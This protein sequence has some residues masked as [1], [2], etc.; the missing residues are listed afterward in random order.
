MSTEMSRDEFIHIWK[1]CD[2]KLDKSLT[3]NLY[4]VKDMQMRKVRTNLNS[5]IATRIL[6]IVFGLAWLLLLCVA[7]YFV[8]TQIVMAVSIGVFIICTGVAIIDY[9]RDIMTLQHISY[10]ESILETQE[11]LAVLQRSMIRSIRVLWL[12]L[13]FW[14]TFFISNAFIRDGGIRF[15]IIQT[16]I[17]LFFVGLTV[18]LFRNL[19]PENMNKKK[20]V[21]ALIN[22]SGIRKVSR[23]MTF[24]RELEDFKKG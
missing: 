21:K 5:M 19:I 7:F 22:D 6:G 17:T 10:V 4:L 2:E 15:W 16:P 8:R 13:P 3:L 12:Q 9:I 11:K 14:S 24:I 1:A 23:A 18:V 20:W